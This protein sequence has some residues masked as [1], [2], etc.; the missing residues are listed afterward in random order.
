MKESKN[1]I[2][3][4][5]P[6]NFEWDPKLDITAYELALCLNLWNKVVYPAELTSVPES[7]L[8]HFKIKNPNL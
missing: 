4:L 7:V 1:F 3:L 6:I 5:E 8:R 2:A